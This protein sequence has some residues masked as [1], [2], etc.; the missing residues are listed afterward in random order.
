MREKVVITSS[1]CFQLPLPIWWGVSEAKRKKRFF[2]YLII[3][4]PVEA[5]K[6]ELFRCGL[7][8]LWRAARPHNR[9]HFAARK[10]T[11]SQFEFERKRNDSSLYAMEF[12]HASTWFQAIHC[13]MER[14][15]KTRN[16]FFLFVKQLLSALLNIE[17]RMYACILAPVRKCPFAIRCNLSSSCT[18]CCPYHTTL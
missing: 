2:I 15:A 18:T 16:T 4:T 7:E 10:K 3:F 17:L 1:K 6:W 9:S 11:D 5:I 8:C 14:A 13:N 12:G